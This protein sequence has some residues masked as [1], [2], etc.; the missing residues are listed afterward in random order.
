M[1]W[2]TEVSDDYNVVP[3]TAKAQPH[4]CRANTLLSQIMERAHELHALVG[5]DPEAVVVRTEGRPAQNY[6]QFARSLLRERRD[7]D[8]VLAT[9][10]L[11]D[12]AWDMVLDLF[13]TG[14]AGKTVPVS[15]LCHGSGVPP[16]TALRWLSVLAERNLISRTNDPRDKRRVN[17]SLK[18]SARASMVKYL[19]RTATRR[20]ITLRNET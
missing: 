14:E 18:P 16:T 2:G 9:E 13:A 12:P 19:E 7:R 4:E 8:L 3:F 11:G 17:V 10:L 20:G 5:S 15:S 6:A 1:R